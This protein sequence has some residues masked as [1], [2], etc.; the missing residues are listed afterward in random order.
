MDADPQA[1]RGGVVLIRIGVND[2]GAHDVMDEL[3]RDPAA[4]RPNARID[5]CVAAIG[6]AL[7][8]IRKRHP[9]TWVV[10]VG[11]LSNADWSVE[12]GNWRSARAIANIDAG[13]DRFDNG[14]RRLAATD[15]HIA[16]LDD[17]AWF[18]ARWGARDA[19]GMPRY[20][21]VRLAPGWAITNTSGDDPHHAVVADGHAGTVWNAL[22]AQHLVASLNAAFG[23]HLTPITDAEV[24][25]FVQPGFARAAA[26]TANRRDLAR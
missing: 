8:L 21:T 9:D 17:R 25:R 24:V 2:I 13:L 11:V 14:L 3:S 5:G 22:W 23:L 7:A 6:D 20:K 4:A 12:F 15:R 18:R 1:W 16:F 10:L 19:H 26:G